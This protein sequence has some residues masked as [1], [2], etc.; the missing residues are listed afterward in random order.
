[1]VS[2]AIESLKFDDQERR[3]DDI[4]VASAATFNW[5]FRED[6]VG[7]KRW[8][9]QGTGVYWIR[10][11]PGSGKSTLFRHIRDNA[12]FQET[13]NSRN[14]HVRYFDYWHFFTTRGSHLQNSMEGLLRGLLNELARQSRYLST[15]ITESYRDRSETESTAWEYGELA[16]ALN[17]VLNQHSEEAVITVYIDALDEFRG[18]PERI[19]SFINNHQRN[20]DRGTKLRFCFTCREWDAFQKAFADQPGFQ[21]QAYTQDD[22]KRYARSRLQQSKAGAELTEPLL[23]LI[24]RHAHGVFLWVKLA[25]AEIDLLPTDTSLEQIETCINNLPKDL[26]QFYQ[27]IMLRIPDHEKRRVHTFLEI[28]ARSEEP[29][30]VG[31]LLEA[32]SCSSGTS[33]AECLQLLNRHRAGECNE[34]IDRS[35]KIRWYKYRHWM[36]REKEKTSIDVRNNESQLT[37]FCGGL[38]ECKGDKWLHG[39]LVTIVQFAHRT[40]QDFVTKPGL[41][42]LIFDPGLLSHENGFTYCV[43]YHSVWM[44]LNRDHHNNI[45]KV[46]A[47]STEVHGTRLMVWAARDHEETLGLASSFLRTLPSDFMNSVVKFGTYPFVHTITRTTFEL[48]VCGGLQL[49]VRE[50]LAPSS[51]SELLRSHP[52]ILNSLADA[53]AWEGSSDLKRPEITRMLL[54]AGFKAT[55]E[56]NN[57]TPYETLFSHLFTDGNVSFFDPG[58]E[59]IETARILIKA[60]GQDPNQRIRLRASKPVHK[61]QDASEPVAMVGYRLRLCALHIAE[62]GLL[63]MVL[64]CGANPNMQ[65]TYGNTALDLRIGSA[66]GDFQ[67]IYRFFKAQVYGVNTFQDSTRLEEDVKTLLDRGAKLTQRGQLVRPAFNLLCRGLFGTTIESI[68]EV[69][70]LDVPV[71]TTDMPDYSLITPAHVANLFGISRS[72]KHPVWSNYEAA[73]KAYNNLLEEMK[74]MCEDGRESRNKKLGL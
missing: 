53:I 42:G 59:T 67:P 33:F 15:L 26:E 60:T 2:G 40:V 1:M 41:A 22:I 49:L 30:S 51:L 8:I 73:N 46:V 45:G 62:G 56:Q 72:C 50:F 27:T 66:A 12:I 31:E 19:A 13:L 34:R 52:N 25:T 64:E 7:F 38:I 65:D 43:K 37:N 17:T 3:Y 6:V 14:V 4:E 28:I 58:P 11:K 21:L 20:D 71:T 54:E 63:R 36:N 23:N 61:R 35:H 74:Q 55:L 29:M 16:H 70:I 24:I 44:Q 47:P 69:E 39:K 5:I 68:D 32:E 57:L 9:V 18:E 48:A 10:G